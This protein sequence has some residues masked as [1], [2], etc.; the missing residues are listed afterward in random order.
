MFQPSHYRP[1]QGRMTANRQP[2]STPDLLV[3]PCRVFRKLHGVAINRRDRGV[4]IDGPLLG[5]FIAN[6][7]C[8]S[9]RARLRDDWMDRVAVA[10]EWIEAGGVRQ[11]RSRYRGQDRAVAAVAG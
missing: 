7:T 6:E 2:Q 4:C 10:I 5:L 11:A 3:G 8:R 1:V 9:T